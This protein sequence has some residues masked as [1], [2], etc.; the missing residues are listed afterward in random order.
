MSNTRRFQSTRT[1]LIAAASAFGLAATLQLTAAPAQAADL[2]IHVKVNEHT[3]EKSNVT[4]NLPISMLHAAVAMVDDA[5]LNE[6]RIRFNESDINAADLRRMWAELKSSP[7][8]TFVHVESDKEHV[9]ITKSGGYVVAT[10][11][12]R[13][14]SKADVQA[15]IPVA[16]VD[17]L[18]SSNDPNTLDLQAAIQALAA[19]GEGDLVSV[20][21]TDATV[22]VWVDSRPEAR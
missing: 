13:G 22:R 21:D 1:R 19:H 7:D 9:K 2:W 4:V 10:V 8:A 14:D 6:N 16:V 11:V 20:T 15:R 3:G 12:E 17:A 18:L 5:T